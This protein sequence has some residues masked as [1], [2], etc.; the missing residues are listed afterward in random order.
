[1]KALLRGGVLLVGIFLLPP[2]ESLAGQDGTVQGRVRDEEGTAVFRATV[3]LLR[4]G[5]PVVISDMDRLGSFR[6]SEVAPGPYTVRVQGLGYSEYS[7]EIVI[8]PTETVDLDLR[9]QRS[10]I[11]IE[12][13]SVE[14]ERSR[15]RARFEQV[16]GATIRDLN[17]DAVRTVPGLAE[18]DP[19]RALEVLPGVVSTS[20]FSAS[21]H[22]RGGS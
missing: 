4:S 20:D 1:M 7:E 19:V 17:L 18:P 16:G 11:Q 3:V 9:L 15:A 8:G 5:T 22:V 10:A 6:I 13:I 12:G 14:A 2:L 21:F